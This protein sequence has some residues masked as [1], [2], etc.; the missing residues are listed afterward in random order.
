MDSIFEN[1]P[2]FIIYIILGFLFLRV[3]KY[4]CTL[5]NSNE[6]E[7]VLMESILVGFILKQGYNLIIPSIND[8]IDIIIMII[9]TIIIAIL[10]AKLYSSKFIDK[11]LYMMGVHRTRNKYIWK[12]IEDQ[13]YRIVVDVFNPDTNEAYHGVV[14]YYEEFKEHPQ[15]V[16]NYYQYFENWHN[17]KV[18][19]DFSKN[20]N[21]VVIVDTEQFSRVTISYDKNSHK[22][23]PL[24]KNRDSKKIAN[25][26]IGLK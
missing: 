26:R 19:M 12:D 5:K 20:P 7:H 14:I 3:F 11:F 4:M 2:N 13:D 23:K 25:K 10:F 15:I 22:I 16:L 21:K 9:I 18:T 6:Y 8:T 17:G 24:I 1:L